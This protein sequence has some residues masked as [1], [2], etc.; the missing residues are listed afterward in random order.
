MVRDGRSPAYG[1]SVVVVAWGVPLVVASRSARAGAR[2]LHPVDN[3]VILG[4]TLLFLWKNLWISLC[5]TTQGGG[6]P[7]WGEGGRRLAPSH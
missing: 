5:I 2:A 6:P 3:V 4:I 7:W 1:A